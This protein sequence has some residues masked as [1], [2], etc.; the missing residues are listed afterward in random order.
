MMSEG[1]FTGNVSSNHLL[2]PDVAQ[3]EINAIRNDQGHALHEAYHSAEHPNHQKAI[4]EMEK[5]YSLAYGEEE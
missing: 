4:Q 5:L 1:S 3:T 2:S